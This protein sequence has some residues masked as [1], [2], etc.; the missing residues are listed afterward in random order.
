MSMVGRTSR[1]MCDEL[2][3]W[4]GDSS[5]I[6]VSDGTQTELVHGVV[7]EY[8]E[9]IIDGARI[10]V[11]DLRV[12]VSASDLTLSE[13]TRIKI[14]NRWYSVIN[15]MLIEPGDYAFRY[16]YQVRRV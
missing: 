15:P 4:L 11:G 1:Q 12:A 9:A 6:T 14:D 10:K 3:E 8:D 2:I 5:Q 16:E 13:V 7:L